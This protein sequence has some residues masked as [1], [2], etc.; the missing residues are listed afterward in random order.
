MIELCLFF[1]FGIQWKIFRHKITYRW[2]DASRWINNLKR[3]RHKI[4]VDVAKIGSI[5]ISGT[6][7]TFF[8]KSF[9]LLINWHQHAWSKS[10]LPLWVSWE[11]SELGSPCVRHQWKP[12]SHDWDWWPQ[13]LSS[14]CLHFYKSWPYM[15]QQLALKENQNFVVGNSEK[16]FEFTYNQVTSIC[17]LLICQF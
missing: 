15:S 13:I 5:I 12:Q 9:T 11:S 8:Q 2:T 17:N 7:Q 4:I 6:I 3:W 1:N 14:S 10:D 16:F